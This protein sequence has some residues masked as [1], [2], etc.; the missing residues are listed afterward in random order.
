MVSVDFNES[1][2]WINPISFIEMAPQQVFWFRFDNNNNN[3]I[4]NV[5]IDSDRIEHSVFSTKWKVDQIKI[6]SYK[7]E[8]T[9]TFV[10][11]GS[12]FFVYQTKQ[13]SVLFQICRDTGLLKTAT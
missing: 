10:A 11:I 5:A 6:I 13:G 2:K 7:L 4:D 3:I 9:L 1:V 12:S 8:I